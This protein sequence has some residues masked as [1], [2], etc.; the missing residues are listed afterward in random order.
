M[1]SNFAKSIELDMNDYKYKWEV[2]EFPP[3]CKSITDTLKISN[4]SSNDFQIQVVNVFQNIKTLTLNYSC[5]V[6]NS[7]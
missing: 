3:N 1:L 4:F 7:G 2:K 5:I 6:E